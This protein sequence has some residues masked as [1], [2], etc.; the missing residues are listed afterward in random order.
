MTSRTRIPFLMVA[1]AI[2]C[3]AAPEKPAPA[4]K[5][6]ECAKLRDEASYEKKFDGFRFIMHG[7]DDWLF[8]TDLDLIEKF[9]MSDRVR[10]DFIRLQN[11]LKKNGTKLVV[12]FLPTRG[13]A[14]ADFL[15]ESDPLT[16]AYDAQAVQAN[17]ESFIAGLQ[18]EKI[19]F[20]GMTSGRLNADF[21]RKA[22]HHWT[23]GGAREMAWAVANYVKEKKLARGVPHGEFVTRAGE[24]YD[25]PS[26][27]AKPLA[28]LCNVTV[29]RAQDVMFETVEK[30]TG[31]AGQDL[32]ADK[33]SPAVVLVGTSN[34]KGDDFHSNFDGNLK[35]FLSTD[36]YNAAISGGGYDDPM[37]AYLGSEEYRKSPPKL[38]VWE[39]PGYYRMDSED[40][41]KFFRQALPTLMGDCADEVLFSSNPTVLRQKEQ[42]LVDG[43][44]NEDWA[45]KNFYLVLEFDQPVKKHFS[46]TLHRTGGQADV[47]KFKRSKFYPH[48]GKFFFMP[49]GVNKNPVQEI[50]LK[51]P[52]EM[53][54]LTVTARVCASADGDGQ[55]VMD[56][57]FSKRK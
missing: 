11:L 5:P 24:P 26:S 50:E 6:P 3:A 31:N 37:L 10:D 55:S 48:D 19:H 13:F 33:E 39:I 12:A 9:T 34:S 32:F 20:V 52:D 4:E 17:Y 54:N 35:E 18:K 1:L 25:F 46:V 42:I 29:P 41:G 16:A 22:D 2:L 38:I 57:I 30:Q 47:L 43:L 8:R 53:K 7:K 14:A 23:S 21:Y 40:I 15:P 56:A 51:I 44:E 45:R 49:K 27:F 36:V 28:E